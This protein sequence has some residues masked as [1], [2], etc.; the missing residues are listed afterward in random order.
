M[1][2]KLIQRI[3]NK[4]AQTAPAPKPIP[5]PPDVPSILFAQLNNGYSSNTV[6]TL[7]QLAEILNDAAHYA[8]QGQDNFQKFV[9][10]SF[11]F[12]PSKAF[13]VDQKHINLLCKQFYTTFLNSR[14]AFSA[15]VPAQQIHMWADGMQN[16]PDL[17]AIS[18]T[19]PSGPAP[20]N[21]KTSISDLLTHIKQ[22]NPI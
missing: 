16:S 17:S 2:T 12:D 18:Q 10:N 14:N 6:Q 5:S 9:N 22:Q 3:L 20:K 4:M 11:S 8:S 19:N 15:K 21:L 1:R 13:S 7:F